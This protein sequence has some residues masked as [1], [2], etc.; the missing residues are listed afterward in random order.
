M[1]CP[2]TS[3]G[4]LCSAAPG[5][6]PE[7]LFL[8]TPAKW[9]PFL[10]GD[11]PI[12]NELFARRVPSSVAGGAFLQVFS[13]PGRSVPSTWALRGRQGLCATPAPGFSASAAPPAAPRFAGSPNPADP[14]T[15]LQR[16]AGRSGCP[17]LVQSLPPL[18]D[19]EARPAGLPRATPQ[20]AG[21]S[22][23]P[24]PPGRLLGVHAVGSRAPQSHRCCTWNHRLPGPGGQARNGPRALEIKVLPGHFY[25]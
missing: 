1:L 12:W 13:P 6:H 21:L 3:P 4:V 8:T 14:T 15:E 16:L 17:G 10:G 23:I 7:G 5:H 19:S 9:V 22:L 18:E 24:R 25:V 2:Q 11:G 20:G